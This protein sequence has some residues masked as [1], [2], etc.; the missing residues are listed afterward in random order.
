MCLTSRPANRQ[1]RALLLGAH[2][3]CARHLAQRLAELGDVHLTG[4]DIHPEPPAWGRLDSYSAADVGDAEQVESLVE[5]TRPDW[6]FNLA[7]V[8]GG[9]SADVYRV[10]VM[11]CVNLLEAVG[12]HA[13]EARVLAVGSAA[14]YGYIT[15]RDLPVTEGQP[16]RPV[17]DY[18]VSKHAM[19]LAA[20]DIARRR[21]IRL[22]VARPFNIIGA[23]LP[24]SLVVGAVLRRAREA[25]AASE[26]PVV[27]V[28]NLDTERDFVAAEDVAD[29]YLCM[30]QGER[31]GEVFNICSGRPVAIREVVSMALSH[32][33]RPIRLEVD[34]ALVRPAD[35]Q[36][37]YGSY[38]KAGLAFGFRPA[39]SIEESIRRAWDHMMQS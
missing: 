33:T 26:H 36:C 25:L 23:G 22:V 37:I 16:C 34:P 20:L 11:G 4:S 14:E 28:G 38:E 2:G 19:T 30:I 10:N 21:G 18:G 1:T 12:A 32:S 27:K 8:T 15:A 24:A 29:A 9:R 17:G 35:V 6:V 3:F 13:Q 31:W 7:G 39:V 5:S